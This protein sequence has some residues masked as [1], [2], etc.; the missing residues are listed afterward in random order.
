MNDNDPNFY[1]K[2]KDDY[3]LVTVGVFY[4][5]PEYSNIIQEFMWQTDDRVPELV[6]VHKFLN[7]WHT[8]IDA[9][10][11]EVRISCSDPFSTSNFKKIDYEFPVYWN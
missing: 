5:L 10:I 1:L 11:S 6:R 8:N 7:H 9:V 3:R 2:L 4:Y